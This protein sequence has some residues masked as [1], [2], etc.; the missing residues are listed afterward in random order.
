MA[1]AISNIYADSES[2]NFDINQTLITRIHASILKI[3]ATETG[4]TFKKLI[5]AITWLLRNIS[6]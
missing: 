6:F 4:R 5:Q 2:E 3:K 1:H